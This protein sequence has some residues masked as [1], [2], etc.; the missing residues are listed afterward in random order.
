MLLFS[1]FIYLFLFVCLFS[2]V[3][4]D[5]SLYVA[6]AVMELILSVF[7]L[8]SNSKRSSCLCLLSA[9]IKGVH[10][11]HLAE[12]FNVIF[13]PL[14]FFLVMT[15]F[16]YLGLKNNLSVGIKGTVLCTHTYT[17]SLSPSQIW[18]FCMP[19][20]SCVVVCLCLY[21]RQKG[22]IGYPS[23]SLCLFFYG[24]ISVEVGASF[25]SSRLEAASSNNP[26]VSSSLG[27]G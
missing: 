13:V 23:L 12:I 3:F 21:R 22:S 6:V 5:E 25:V 27:G 15:R 10:Y 4:R 1:L 17:H 8:A 20:Y 26:P 14:I 16:Y 7:R 11:H 24:R 9:G 19:V 2:F 18:L